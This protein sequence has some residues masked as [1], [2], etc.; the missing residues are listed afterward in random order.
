M[1]A[2]GRRCKGTMFPGCPRLWVLVVLGS[3]W[4]GPRSPGAEAATLR[5]FYV[6]AQGIRWN[7]RPEPADQR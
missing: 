2:A 6:A 7:Y 3:S 5:Q 4:A 1:E